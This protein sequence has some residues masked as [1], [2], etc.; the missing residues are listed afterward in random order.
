MAIDLD[1]LLPEIV[2][3]LLD[4]VFVVDEAGR[5]VFVSRAC[6]ALLGYTQQEMVGTFVIDHVHPQDRD[7]TRTAAER[8]IGGASHIDFENRYVRKDGGVVHILWSAR[9]SE[10]HRV[11]I[12][13]ARDVTALKRA[14][15][16]RS[17][18][19]RIS[20]AAH[21]E[22]SLPALCREIHRA[23]ADLLPADK[24]YVALYDLG[25]ETIA[26]PYFADHRQSPRQAE[27]LPESAM[28][29]VI[30]TGKAL[31]AMQG[32]DRSELGA[33]PASSE[34]KANW[35]GV[36][37][38]S[39]NDVVG[40]VILE[41][42]MPSEQYTDKHLDLLQFVS[43]Q[44]ATAIER[45]QAQERLRHMAHHDALTGLPNRVLF[46]DRLEMALR[47]AR[48]D[49]EYLALLYLDLDNLK[50]VNDTLG[51]ETGDRLLSEVASRLRDCTR[52]SDTIARMGGDE[53]TVLLTNVAGSGS[54]DI[55]VDKIHSAMAVPLQG[56]GYTLNLSVSIGVAVYPSDGEEAG[57]L[58]RNADADMYT[59]KQSARSK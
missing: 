45:K 36:P 1:A 38:V 14:E 3:L 50:T 32:E 59:Q 55:V 37:L 41:S 19:Y 26:F 12:A 23:I 43:T 51:H 31:L 33:K 40:A 5:I 35:L 29:E 22:D 25:N 16:V 42:G 30:R 4:P 9:W 58:V 2:D 10:E 15:N 34:I 54:A 17:A 6:N 13:V 49:Q 28:A 21:A 27:P 44:V 7:R 11:R 46:Y 53:F 47:R 57:S 48:R 18:L 56:D 8:V 24:F 20:E 52:V 39:G